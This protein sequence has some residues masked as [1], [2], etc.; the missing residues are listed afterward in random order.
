MAVV[1]A[2]NERTKSYFLFREASEARFALVIKF[3]EEDSQKVISASVN[4]LPKNT[5]HTLKPILKFE[6]TLGF[7]KH[8]ESNTLSKYVSINF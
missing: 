6:T 7:L 4:R 8:K 2:F 5:E 1:L 3:I